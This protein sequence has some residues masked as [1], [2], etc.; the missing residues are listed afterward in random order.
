MLANDRYTYRV[1][2]SEEDQEYLGLCAE[3]PSL[4]WLAATPEQALEG[5]RTVVANVV[6]DMQSTGEVVPVT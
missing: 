3:F 2:W 1:T 5:I 6:S 4:G